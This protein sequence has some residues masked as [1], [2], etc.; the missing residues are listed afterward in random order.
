[1]IGRDLC[2]DLSVYLDLLAS[3]MERFLI[4]IEAESRNRVEYNINIVMVIVI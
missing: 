3:Q 1:M 2:Y 4:D